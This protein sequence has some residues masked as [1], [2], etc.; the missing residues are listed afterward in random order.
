VQA[1]KDLRREMR[2]K[3]TDFVASIPETMRALILN[4]PPAAIA[5]LLKGHSMIGLYVPTGDEAPALGWA[6]WLHENGWQIALPRTSDRDTAMV[7]HR[8]DNPWDEDALEPGLAG[9]PQPPAT[10]T[11]VIPDALVVPLV[12]FT[13]SGDRLGQGAGHYDRWLAAHG[14]VPTIGLAWDVQ[15]VESLPIEEHDQRLT[16]IVTPTRIHWSQT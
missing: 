9:I 10:W 7:F 16:A 2:A 3:R 15:E 13:A 8:W 4:R 11:E 6:R 1:K 14:A 12:A 5:E